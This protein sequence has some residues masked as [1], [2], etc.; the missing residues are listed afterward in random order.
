MDANGVMNT[1]E[2]QVKHRGKYD[3]PRPKSQLQQAKDFV[4]RELADGAVIRKSVL[5]VKA[6]EEGVMKSYM[7]QAKRDLNIVVERD[8]SNKTFWTWRLPTEDEAE[9]P[10]YVGKEATVNPATTHH[11]CEDEFSVTEAERQKYKIRPDEQVCWIRDPAYWKGKVPG[12]PVRI[13][14]RENPGGRVIMYEGQHVANGIDVIMAVRPMAEVEAQR[15]R[16]QA[17]VDRIARQTS[18]LLRDDDFNRND[19][20]RLRQQMQINS[21]QHRNAGMIGPASPSQGMAYE[22]YVRN[23][24]LSDAQIER[25]ELSYS[26]GPHYSKVLSDEQAEAMEAANRRAGGRGGDR[27]SSGKTYSL[28]PTIRPRNLATR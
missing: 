8:P 7:D 15:R 9:R 3:N 12:D 17:E 20:A 19:D 1:T 16:D 14:E 13:F 25:E 18:Q 11:L 24:G 5:D 26:L 21:E 10:A 27:G 4:K 6:T 2:M 22:E 23:R 28:P